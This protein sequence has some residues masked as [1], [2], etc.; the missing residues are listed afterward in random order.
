MKME[1]LRTFSAVLIENPEHLSDLIPLI[2]KLTPYTIFY[3]DTD[4]P[5]SKDVQDFLKNTCAQ[6][7]DFSNPSELLRL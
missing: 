4:K 5:Q 7:T 2:R 3:P 6:A 1:G